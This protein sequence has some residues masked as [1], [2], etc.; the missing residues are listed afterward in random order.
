MAKKV[1][2][3][4]QQSI[5]HKLK[6]YTGAKYYNG[7]SLW[8]ANAPWNV[9][10]S[11]RSDGKSL[12]F[13]KQCV[14]D[15]LNTGHKFAYVRRYEDQIKQ[16]DVNLYFKDPNFT[17]WLQK[18]SDYI[19][20]RCNRGELWLQK[21][22]DDGGSYDADLIG[23]VFALNVQEKYKS[24]HYDGVYNI[25][26]EEFITNKLYLG[27]GYNEYMEFNHL[28]ST[29]CRSGKYRALLIGNTISRDCP[30]LLEMGIDLFSTTPGKIYESHMKKANGDTIKCLF[31]YVAPKEK[32]TFFFGKA[33][34]NIVGGQ[35][36]V[37]EQPHLFFKFNDAEV[38]YKCVL[39][40]K[41]RQAFKLAVIMFEDNKYLFVWPDKYDNAIQSYDDIFT[42]TADFEKGYFLKPEKK[43]HNKIWPLIRMKRVLFSDNLTGTEF[44]KAIKRY[45]PFVV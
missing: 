28:I 3:N 26:F 40:T 44:M 23:Y 16:K 18:G 29:L 13:L 36:D 14:I 42:D 45:N 25:I 10:L 32:D 35:W 8:A 41:L 19:G 9:I 22:N 30:Y 34:K 1:V 4:G 6:N 20:I 11:E 38:L 37:D 27:N 43:R 15:F 21:Q 7:S 31:D 2:V 12:W 33:E 39:I 24:L 5:P 17:S